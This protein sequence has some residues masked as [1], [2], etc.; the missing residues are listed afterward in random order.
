MM[1][2]QTAWNGWRAGLRRLTQDQHGKGQVRGGRAERTWLFGAMGFC[3]SSVWMYLE[4]R[5]SPWAALLSTWSSLLSI[6]SLELDRPSFLHLFILFMG[7]SRQECWSGLPFAFPGDHILSLESPLDGM[8]I[9]PVNPKGNQHWLFIKRP[10]AEAETPILWSPDVK[11]WHIGKDPDAGEDRGQ[12][13][14]GD[15]G[16][17][18]WMASLTQWTQ[19]SNFGRQWRTGKLGMLLSMGSQS[20]TRLSNWTTT[21]SPHLSDSASVCL[22]PGIAPV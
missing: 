2:I 6:F 20:Q 7:F 18:G 17:D 5:S 14:V 1:I 19:F 22:T 9:K 11:N 12:G 10:D 15:R 3:L 21:T 13:K 8:E 4:P 16:W